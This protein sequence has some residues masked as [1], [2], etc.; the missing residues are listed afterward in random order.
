P[1]LPRFNRGRG[2]G[3]AQKASLPADS[4]YFIR[5]GLKEAFILGRLEIVHKNPTIILDGAHNSD[6]VKAL[7]TAIKSIYPDRKVTSIVAIKEDKKSE[8]MLRQ[9]L[10]ISKRVIFTKFQL[11]ADIGIIKSYD[12]NELLNIAR[13]I[14]KTM[15][16][17]VISDAKDAIEETIQSAKEDDIILVTGSLYLIGE[18]KKFLK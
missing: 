18:V 1:K 10:K 3:R 5:K 9:I 15:P 13:S 17:S 16:L 6:K 14:E 8:E 4:S 11:T 2:R 7:V 12:P